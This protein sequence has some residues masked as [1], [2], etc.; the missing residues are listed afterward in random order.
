MSV[1]E[2]VAASKIIAAEQSS[3]AE[4]CLGLCV[5]PFIFVGRN[6]ILAPVTLPVVPTG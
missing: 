3:A 5:S 1:A 2:A 4:A 6:L